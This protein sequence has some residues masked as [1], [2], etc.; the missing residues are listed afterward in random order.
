M[1]QPK[2]LAGL[3]VLDMSQGIAGP[4]C[5]GHFA[6]Y[7]RRASSRSSRPRATG[8]AALGTRIAGTSPQAIVY[9][10]GK[11]SL[12]LDLK[13]AARPRHRAEARR[14]GRRW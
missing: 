14:A 4:S 5:G 9:N 3:F 12:A 1:D 2:P 8:C 11:E 6:E 13:T 10:R 7:R